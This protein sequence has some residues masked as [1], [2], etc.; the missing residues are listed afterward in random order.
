MQE[1]YGID[2]AIMLQQKKAEESIDQLKEAASDFGKAFG[3]NRTRGYK[4]SA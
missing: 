1:C 4:R 2:A 3:R